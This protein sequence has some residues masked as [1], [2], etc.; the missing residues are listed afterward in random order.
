[1]ITNNDG[2]PYRLRGPNPIMSGQIIWDNIIYHNLDQ[3]EEI[4]YVPRSWRFKEIKNEEK[5]EEQV[6]V[7]DFSAPTLPTLELDNPGK[8]KCWVLPTE[9][10][11][12]I[13]PLYGQESKRM[14][15]GEKYTMQ[16]AF[17]QVGDVYSIF[18]TNAIK[19]INNGSIIYVEMRHWKVN[20]FTK[21]EDGNGILIHCSI[22]DQSPSFG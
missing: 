1:M 16:I 10:K 21:S 18:W 3:H 22:T 15:W 2:N 9:I 8:M 6:V 12:T 5:K 19:S 4:S 7:S 11:T 13:D 20:S 14:V 17:E